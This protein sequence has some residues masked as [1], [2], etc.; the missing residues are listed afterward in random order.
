MIKNIKK[1][2]H[3]GF[4]SAAA[5][6]SNSV[7]GLPNY[8]KNWL[9]I[10][11]FPPRER[12]LAHCHCWTVSKLFDFDPSPFLIMAL[13]VR[14][15]LRRS[16]SPSSSNPFSG[17]V[18]G[19]VWRR[20]MSQEAAGYHLSGGPAHM[21]GAVFWEVNRPL[22]IEDFHMPRPKAGEVLIKTK[23][24][25]STPLHYVLFLFFSP[26]ISEMIGLEFEWVFWIYSLIKFLLICSKNLRNG[27]SNSGWF[28]YLF[29]SLNKLILPSQ[30]VI[31]VAG[32]LHWRYRKFRI[33]T[34]LFH[35]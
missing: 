17:G 20:W 29:Y 15:L 16:S 32:K 21:R 31:S 6:H 19:A 5:K 23:G 28:I 8:F 27:T 1:L 3:C 9:H 13:L 30:S 25:I 4:E 26:E 2:K 24:Q 33:W 34:I 14:S 18:G 7:A 10:F 12:G 35:F 11:P 22:T